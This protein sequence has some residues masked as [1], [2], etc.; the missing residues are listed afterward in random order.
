MKEKKVK[1]RLFNIKGCSEQQCNSDAICITCVKEDFTSVSLEILLH[2]Q[3][4]PLPPQK[5]HL[6]PE[7]EEVKPTS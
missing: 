4:L 3:L 6:H 7:R 5:T 2:Y 1:N